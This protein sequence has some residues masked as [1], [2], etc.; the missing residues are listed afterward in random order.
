VRRNGRIVSD[1][2][3]LQAEFDFGA[4]TKTAYAVSWG[5]ISTAAR[6]TGI[7][8]VE[9][10]FE[11]TPAVTTMA[12]LNRNWGWIMKNSTIRR[13]SEEQVTRLPQYPLPGQT[14]G[15]VVVA[16]VRDDEGHL[17]ESRLVTPE[18]YQFTACCA[19]EI[20]NAVAA[21]HNRPG[22]ET[23]ASLLGPDFVL[24]LESVERFDSV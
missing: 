4:G 16:R 1:R 8:N 6:S 15:V 9:V 3:I 14:S 24:N 5:D 2:R 21:G 12:F 7:Q 18:A 11:A 22:F 13:W 17:C 20:A 19:V 23:P 10:Y